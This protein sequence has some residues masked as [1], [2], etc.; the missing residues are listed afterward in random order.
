MSEEEKASE[1][2]S[3]EHSVCEFITEWPVVKMREGREAHDVGRTRQ[4]V[5]DLR[6]FKRI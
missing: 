3:N 2:T 1:I 5:E 4:T 6:G